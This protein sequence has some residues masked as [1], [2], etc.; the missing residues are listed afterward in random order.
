MRHVYSDSTGN[1]RVGLAT[2]GVGRAG[3][4]PFILPPDRGHILLVEDDDD[5]RTFMS[6]MLEFDGH[7]VDTV[8]TASDALDRLR[9]NRYDLVV[10]DYMLPDITG[11]GFLQRARSAGLLDHT[12]ALLATAH[13]NPETLDDVPVLYKPFDFEE[14]LVRVRTVLRMSHSA[15]GAA[16]RLVLYVSRG[17]LACR[18]ARRAIRQL[19]DSWPTRAVELTVRDVAD[20]PAAA[21]ADCISYTP[22]L[23]RVSP[24]PRVWIV[25]EPRDD[26]VVRAALEPLA[27]ES[28]RSRA[29][30][31]F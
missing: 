20:D 28:D 19:I 16:I 9:H 22:T 3:Q 27:D 23:L 29:R 31:I 25:G 17:S 8:R 7:D 11:T 21:A 24:G 10:S 26:R 6:M 2:T 18:R 30:S 4:K 13:P 5:A 15:G 12:P 1:R 14:F